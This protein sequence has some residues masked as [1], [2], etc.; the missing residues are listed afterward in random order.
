MG[1]NYFTIMVRL[2]YYISHIEIIFT[3]NKKT[4]KQFKCLLKHTIV[5]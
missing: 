1:K 2:S 5:L 3:S 4:W